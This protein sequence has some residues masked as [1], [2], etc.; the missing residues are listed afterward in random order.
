MVQYF[1]IQIL[2]YTGLLI[3][4][5]EYEQKGCCFFQN[6]VNGLEES[7][8]Y[9]VSYRAQKSV[10]WHS[11]NNFG[12]TA[13]RRPDPPNSRGSV[14]IP[15]L[16]LSGALGTGPGNTNPTCP[17]AGVP[18]I[19]PSSGSNLIGS[20]ATVPVIVG[21]SEAPI[22]NSNGR[23]SLPNLVPPNHKLVSRK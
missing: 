22:I 10:S 3:S 5:F 17:E 2:E 18:T 19:I 14:V 8:D 12:G 23:T 7:T 9:I 6:F 11:L 13:N 4:N 20:N 1:Q 16:L 21:G 15:S